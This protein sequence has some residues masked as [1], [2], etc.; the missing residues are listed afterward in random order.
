[1]RTARRRLADKILKRLAEAESQ[2]VESV[3]EHPYFHDPIGY[4]H[5]VLKIEYLSPDQEEIGRSALKPPYCVKVR[6][7]HSV[8]KTMIA[9]VLVNWFY[10]TRNPGLTVT[11]APSS[12]AVVKLLWAQIR[13]QRK[14]A[15]LDDVFRG[16][17][18]PHMGDAED[19]WAEGFTAQKGESFQGQHPEYMMF[20]FDEDEG[21]EPQYYTTTGTMFV[22]NGKHIWLSF[23]NP[24][25]T[26]SESYRQEQL[27]KE[28][29]SP[30][31]KLFTISAL[32]HPNVIA[33]LA[34]KP[35]PISSAVTVEQIDGWVQDWCTPIDP[36][37]RD[38][39]SI[40]W[41]PGTN[42]W[43]KPGPLFQS[44][45]LGMRPTS[46][47]DAVWS[48][49]AFNRAVSTGLTWQWAV[50]IPE[51]GVDVARFGDDWTVL[52]G[53][54]GPCS[55]LHEAGNGW[56]VDV[57]VGRIIDALKTLADRFNRDR[58][59]DKVIP[60]LDPKKIPVKCDDDGV[61]GGV[62][63]LLHAQGYNV[64]PVNAGT[65][66]NAVEDYPNRR[67][68]LWFDVATRARNGMLDLTRLDKAVIGRLRQQAMT[69][70]Y[71]VDYAG[72]RVV[73]PKKDTKKVL[74]RSPDDMDSLNLAYSDDGDRTYP[75]LI[76]KGE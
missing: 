22:P 57:T 34:G 43:Y 48:E 65:I 30:K 49:A 74:G 44:R 73:E 71:T 25:T 42:R 38:S 67:S 20:V 36:R 26:T 47:T 64:H 46:A 13:L 24:T 3:A 59:P 12:R 51:L 72:R 29:G 50:H 17:V 31:W 33:G 37:D 54:Q 1:M 27:S 23:G 41:R 9:A 40:E 61:G 70:K 5:D 4:A 35:I 16:N 52:H 58:P 8:G 14:A 19:H 63:D 76:R 45:V 60:Y 62:T 66:P 6:A 68:E 39:D 56:P 28:D 53:R 11:T 32:N 10:D 69:P 75:K 7:G 21:I 2:P 15:G 18:A 55:I